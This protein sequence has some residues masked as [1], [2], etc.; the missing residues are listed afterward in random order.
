MHVY[1]NKNASSKTIERFVALSMC[2]SEKKVAKK[3]PVLVR[4]SWAIHMRH[5]PLL[6]LL[7][8]DKI[9]NISAVH[10][11]LCKLQ[12]TEK[13]FGFFFAIWL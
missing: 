4:K 6:F 13:Q 10:L 2:N 3:K 11:D 7:L 1:K 8:S 5:W 12:S 9:V